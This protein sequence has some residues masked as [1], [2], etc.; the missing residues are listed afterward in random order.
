MK[1]ASAYLVLKVKSKEL[2]VGGRAGGFDGVAE[3]RVLIFCSEGAGRGVYMADD[4]AVGV[5]GG[6]SAEGGRAE[7]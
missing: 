6:E 1:G 2:G 3:R 7:G 5:V 4:V